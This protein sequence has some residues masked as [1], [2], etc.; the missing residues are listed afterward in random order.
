MTREQHD[1]YLLSMEE[2]LSSP[3]RRVRE[4]GR[5]LERYF[6]PSVDRVDGLAYQ[7]RIEHSK[8][9]SYNAYFS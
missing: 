2:Y 7:E 6:D 4:Y 8:P 3:Y 1:R 9:M 5:Y